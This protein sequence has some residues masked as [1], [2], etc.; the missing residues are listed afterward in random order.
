M[1]GSERFLQWNRWYDSL[2][3]EWRFHFVLWPIIAVG[4]INMVLTV[5]IRFPFGLLLLFGF[6]FLAAVRVPYVLGYTA[7]SL[8]SPDRAKRSNDPP[9]WIRPFV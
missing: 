7:Q 3:Q 4:A 5:A 2:P 1:T 6:V 9:W 8:S